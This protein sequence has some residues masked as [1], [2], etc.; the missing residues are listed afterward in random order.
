MQPRDPRTILYHMQ[1]HIDHSSV[2]QLQWEA[3]LRGNAIKEIT[4]WLRVAS[5]LSQTTGK[6]VFL[7]LQFLLFPHRMLSFT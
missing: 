7:L 5:P 6:N 2:I 1:A 3:A 4:Q